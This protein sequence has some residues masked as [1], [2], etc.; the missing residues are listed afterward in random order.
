MFAHISCKRRAIQTTELYCAA[1]S[2][3]SGLKKQTNMLA[4]LT[5]ISA[6][7]WPI[8]GSLKSRS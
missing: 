5:L 6:E 4:T 1:E 8:P 3:A 2:N 7:Q